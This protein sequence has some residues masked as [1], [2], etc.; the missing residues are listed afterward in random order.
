MPPGGDGPRVIITTGPPMIRISA[1]R[2][3]F[4]AL[5]AGRKIE[6]P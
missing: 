3:D 1:C 4:T 2:G 6:A 5:H